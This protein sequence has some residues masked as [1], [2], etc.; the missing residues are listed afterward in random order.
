MLSAV[1]RGHGMA[2][3]PAAYNSRNEAKAEGR[4][5]VGVGTEMSEEMYQGLAGQSRR[6]NPMPT[7]GR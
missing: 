7:P 6:S 1:P 3:Q 4:N 5:N 2:L